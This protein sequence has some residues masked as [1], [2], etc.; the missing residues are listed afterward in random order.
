MDVHVFATPV[1]L[2]ILALI[3][4]DE[5]SRWTLRQWAVTGS[6]HEGCFSLTSPSLLCPSVT[7]LD[8]PSV[9][10]LCLLDRLDSAG[11]TS[12]SKPVK[13]E[14]DSVLHFDGRYPLSK[15]N[16]FR[17]V[18]AQTEL[19]AQGKT[20]G[21]LGT[22][23]YYLALLKIRGAVARNMKSSE[24]KALL[25]PLADK[26]YVCAALLE[27]A[28]DVVAVASRARRQAIADIV[29][30]QASDEEPPAQSAEVAALDDVVPDVAPVGEGGPAS[31]SGDVVA[32][33]V[34]D[35]GDGGADGVD[36]LY[37]EG[38]RVSKRGEY[39]SGRSRYQA[40]WTIQC[41]CQA[42]HGKCSKSRGV[43]MDDARFLCACVMLSARWLKRV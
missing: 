43:D 14:A 25:L 23:G 18:L 40:R 32:P 31:G 3:G 8:S 7:S 37:I 11:F 19:V 27:Y 9:P 10:V 15:R 24:L 30:Y 4:D 28:S 13:H 39:H 35:G 17:C 20:F 36:V 21:S 6:S 42:V 26:P 33:L 2:D 38:Q 1:K 41:P 34:D 12:V 22:S 29:A 16:Y 5:S